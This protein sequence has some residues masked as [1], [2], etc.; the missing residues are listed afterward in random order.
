[1]AT[2]TFDVVETIMDI[3]VRLDYSN[4]SSIKACSLVCWDFL[5]ICRRCIFASIGLNNVSADI[6]PPHM[7]WVQAGSTRGFQR[8]LSGTP[9]LADYIRHLHFRITPNDLENEALALALKKIRRLK[10]LTICSSF[11]TQSIW[12]DHCLRPALLHLLHL[13]SLIDFRLTDFDN[14]VVAE[15]MPRLS[16]EEFSH[17]GSITRPISAS[18]LPVAPINFRQMSLGPF[19][20]PALAHFGAA[21]C[22]DGRSFMNFGTLTDISIALNSF[23]DLQALRDFLVHCPQLVTV[24]IGADCMSPDSD[25]KALVGLSDM[26][27]PS[28]KTL[29]HIDFYTAF[30]GG[31]EDDP[32]CGLVRELEQI[33]DS[34]IIEEVSVEVALLPFSDCS[35]STQWGRLDSVLGRSGWPN[36][37]RVSVTV[38]VVAFGP[39]V[40]GGI[41]TALREVLEARFPC[42][43]SD[44][45]KLFQI[46]V[47]EDLR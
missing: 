44:D 30:E 22:T 26:I 32:L 3:L 4:L 41:T 9:V 28:L 2:L 16:F 39:V 7:E 11:R 45:S 46:R 10:S 40:E 19:I 15:L 12:N 24:H 18:D 20:S 36:L 8:L 13:P 33:P 25:L 29:R 1:M 17:A 35:E 47:R 6:P 31:S 43:S 34:N 37:H 21:R 27:S 38:T 23:A 42:L 14:F 5:E